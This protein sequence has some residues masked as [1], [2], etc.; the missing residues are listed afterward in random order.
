[1]RGLYVGSAYINSN[2]SA[3]WT[4]PSIPLHLGQA[5]FGSADAQTGKLGG[6]GPRWEFNFLLAEQLR[7]DRTTAGCKLDEWIWLLI[8]KCWRGTTGLQ[9]SG[10]T[11]SARS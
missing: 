7:R 6:R 5:G 2:R 1:M 8:S 3:E 9:T 11:Q 10:Y 4:Q